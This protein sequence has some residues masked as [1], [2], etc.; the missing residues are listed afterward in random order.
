MRNNRIG[1]NG[2]LNQRCALTPDPESILRARTGKI[3]LQHNPPNSGQTLAPQ[4]NAALC[5]EKTSRSACAVRQLLP[6]T[7]RKFTGSAV[8]R[9]RWPC[10]SNR[11]EQPARATFRRTPPTSAYSP[12]STRV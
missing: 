5:Q 3:V 4:R 12:I 9:Q 1:A 6:T 2:F 10:I 8:R 7:Q 11:D